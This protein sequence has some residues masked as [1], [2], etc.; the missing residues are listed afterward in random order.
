ME[1]RGGKTE[2]NFDTKT[3]ITWCRFTAL[4]KASKIGFVANESARYTAYDIP[5]TA[6]AFYKQTWYFIYLIDQQKE[7][8]FLYLKIQKD[9]QTNGRVIT[10]LNFCCFVTSIPSP[11]SFHL[12]KVEG[13]SQTESKA[14]FALYALQRYHQ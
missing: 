11:R 3:H 7:Q 5:C 4:Q 2:V 9:N 8:Q 6:I 14:I 1:E 10:Y 12:E 13:N